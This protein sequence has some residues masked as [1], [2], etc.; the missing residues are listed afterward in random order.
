MR[1]AA[2]LVCL[3][4]ALSACKKDAVAP[5]TPAKVET[6]KLK[7]GL[8][9]DVGGRGDQS[10][11]DS[12]IRGLEL[13]GAG[14]LYSPTGYTPVADAAFQETIPAE[15]KVLGAL[16][17]LPITP[18]VLQ[19]KS[20]E[21]YEPQLQLAIDDGAALTIGVGF[22]LE[23]AVETV[24][25]R[26]PN[27]KLLLIDSQILDEKNHPYVLPNVATVSFREQEGSYLVG[28]LAALQ[29]QSGKVGFVGGMELPLIKKFEAGFKAGVRATKPDAQILVGYT[30]SFDNPNAG[31]QTAQDL[32]GKGAD[33]LFHAAGSDGLGVISA[34]KDAR[35]SGKNAFVVG[36]DSDQSH[37]AP[38][39]VLTSMVKHVDLA[40]YRQVQ[41]VQAGQFKAGDEDWGLKE[42]GVGLAPIRVKLPNL[43]ALEAAV[44]QA[45]QKIIA[46][47]IKVPATLAELDRKP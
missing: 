47:E 26:N 43:P 28:V 18:V 35:A 30:G 11:N 42:A 5:G 40:V 32:L 22:L 34:V 46:G 4:L 24:A 13:W 2:I 25:K 44:E 41:K 45:R 31:K 16:P 38:E 12:A 21:D 15:V 8:V 23:N 39:A 17:H 33:V 3:G 37:I 1:H 9:S 29:S 6:A 7:I 19:A 20:Q 27:A 36:V 10:F 14:V